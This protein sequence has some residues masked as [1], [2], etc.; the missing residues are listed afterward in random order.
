VA[1]PVPRP[2][3]NRPSGVR[4]GTRPGVVRP[5]TRPNIDRPG[6]RP[7]VDT[8]PGVVSNYPA[9]NRPDR[10]RDRWD[11][12]RGDNNRWDGNRWDNNR[13][14]N[15]RWDGNRWDNNRWDGNQWDNN[16]WDNNRWDNNRWDNNR[17]DNNRWDNNRWDNNRWDNNRWD[18]NRWDNNRWDNNRWDN[19]RWRHGYWQDGHWQGHFH[20]HHSHW[21][22]GWWNWNN[23]PWFWVTGGWGGW[24]SAPNETF[25]YS[26]PYIIDRTTTVF[27]AP[28]D[29]S[30]PL[31][32]P[33]EYVDA[34][35][36]ATL[37][38]VAEQAMTA[39]NS[40]RD[41]FRARDFPTALVRVDE[42]ITL[43]PSDATYHE[44]RALTLFALQR[45]P[46]AAQT[47]Y[48]VLAVGPG[49]TWETVSENYPVAEDYA[50]Q[51]RALEAYIGQYPDQPASRF[52]LAYHYLVIGNQKA[53]ADQLSVVTTLSPNDKIAA[54]L[55]K[56]L[57]TP[58]DA[59][60]AQI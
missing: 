48:S 13:G 59:T 33:T 40:A 42:A 29:Y 4:P 15:N 53:A 44:F 37:D 23:L 18:N 2:D 60:A 14:D 7:G 1:R 50:A 9:L 20:N 31:P 6:T 12:N 22:H 34:G 16:R 41:A 35:A 10:D 27:V 25:V 32:P 8:R 49:W 51:L 21:H 45:F 11:N 39:F 58:A 56:A 24:W 57:T 19:N 36:E 26:N 38:P 17:W 30:Q 46:E 52:L 5:E 3:N 47:I 54:E 28:Y 43:L 55:Y